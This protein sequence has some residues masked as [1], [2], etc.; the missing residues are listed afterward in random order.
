MFKE[1]DRLI[2]ETKTP[3]RFDDMNIIKIM[4][5]EELMDARDTLKQPIMYYNIS[6]HNKCY[7]F[8]KHDD[9]VYLTVIK[10]VDV[11]SGDYK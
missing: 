1:Y 10:A 6:S 5:F 9:D 4:K 3:P 2:V 8:I 11:E 7:F